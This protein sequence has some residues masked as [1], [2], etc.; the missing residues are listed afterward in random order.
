M[1]ASVMSQTANETQYTWR[2]CDQVVPGVHMLAAKV[3]VCCPDCGYGCNV[4]S[5]T[6]ASVLKEHRQYGCRPYPKLGGGMDYALPYAPSP[7][8][9]LQNDY[10]RGENTG[11]RQELLRAQ[12]QRVD[13][14]S[15][16]K[17]HAARAERARDAAASAAETA[18]AA[19]AAA[20]ATATRACD[21][22]ARA[23]RETL[24]Q[25]SRV[26]ELEREC[27]RLA[28]ANRRR[29]PAAGADA[30]ERL[31]KALRRV[32]KAPSRK[33]KF[34]ALLHPDKL[35]SESL[36]A[37]AKLIREAVALE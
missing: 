19:L 27:R 14:V 31:T 25:R 30:C 26:T 6:V 28:D 8:L 3:V 5:H 34:L 17:R 2:S 23:E 12:Q 37:H 21:A 7:E 13:L 18:D 32:M 20:D 11:L 10:V 33:R 36:A 24:A 1:P 22:L 35:S 15:E 9:M 16:A 4:Q 29:S